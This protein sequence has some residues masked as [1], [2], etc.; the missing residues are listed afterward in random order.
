[1]TLLVFLIK[2]LIFL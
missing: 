1:M 2:T